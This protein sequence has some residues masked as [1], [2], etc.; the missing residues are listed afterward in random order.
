V[1]DRT[2]VA[3]AVVADAAGG[4]ADSF[5]NV[6]LQSALGAIGCGTDTGMGAGA[7]APDF[8]R[9]PASVTVSVLDLTCSRRRCEWRELLERRDRLLRFVLVRSSA[10]C[11]WL[12]A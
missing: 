6:A 5:A 9:S 4:G 1:G 3:A 8:A 10:C 7:A 2:A 12:P 11:G